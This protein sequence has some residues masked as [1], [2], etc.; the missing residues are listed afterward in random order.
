MRCSPILAHGGAIAPLLLVVYF[1]VA[2]FVGGIMLMFN[3]KPG[4]RWLGLGLLLCGTITAVLALVFFDA[5]VKF[6][7]DG[8]PH[9]RG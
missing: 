4:L 8:S 9:L 1:A 7:A 6:F 2:S 3:R 5:I